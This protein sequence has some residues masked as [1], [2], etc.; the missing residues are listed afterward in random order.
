[1]AGRGAPSG[2][3]VFSI[4]RARPDLEA[5]LDAELGHHFE[6][7]IEGLCDAGWSEAEARLEAER[8]FG[9]RRQYR[10]DLER[11]GRSRLRRRKW[12]ACFDAFRQSVRLAVRGLRRSPGLSLAVVLLLGLGIGANATMFGVIDRV[13]LRPPPHLES[14]DRLR[15]V[16]LHRAGSPERYR[17]SLTY[18]DSQVLPGAR[19]HAARVDSSNP[20]D[21][22][23]RASAAYTVPRQRTMGSGAEAVKVR[24]QLA[25]AELFPTL[26][27][28]PVAG[29][30]FDHRDDTPGAPLTAVISERFW[31]R[32]FGHDP[33][34]LG[35]TV[36]IRQGRYQIVGV[37]PRGFS[38]AELQT[39]DFWL[40]LRASTAVERSERDLETRTMW[41]V[42][43]VIRLAPGADPAQADALLTTSHITSHEAYRANEA[44]TAAGG[45]GDRDYLAANYLETR[46][47][48][49]STTSV[50]AGRGANGTTSTSVAW[51]L[52]G[53]SAV[54]LLIACAN[55]ANLLLVRGMQKQRDVAVRLALGV[56]RRRLIGQALLEAL[57]LAGCGAVGAFFVARWTGT[58][59]H[60]LLIPQ[61]DYDAAATTPRLLVFI[62]LATCFTALLAGLL[63]A[64]QAF[65]AKA[66]ALGLRARGAVA[67]RSQMRG[68][69]IVVQTALSV[70]LLVAAGLFVRSLWKAAGTD[71]GFEPEQALLVTIEARSGLQHERLMG[72]YRQALE[73]VERQPGIAHA[74]LVSGTTPLHGWSATDVSVSRAAGPPTAFDD[75]IYHYA[76]TSDFFRALG[77]R[78]TLGRAYDADAYRVH[79]PPVAMVSESF[80]RSA[81]PDQS[82]LGQCAIVDS[83]R[84][85]G[86][87]S[88]CR[89]VVGVFEDLAVASLTDRHL[90]AV[91]TPTPPDST[92]LQGMVVRTLGDPAQRMAEIRERIR[93]LSPE[94]RFVN[95]VPM[96]QR[97]ERLTTPWRLGG[98]L[99]SAFGLLA[100]VVAGAGLGSFLAFDVAQRQTELGIRAALG[101]SPRALLGFV[102]RRTVLFVAT[103]LMLGTV[104]A[105]G[106]G[107]FVRDLLFDVT[108]ADPLVF[109]VVFVILGAVGALAGLVPARRATGTDPARTM[110]ET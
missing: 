2:R 99:F 13:L 43:A 1:M 34:V 49:L 21:S 32:H 61:V 66:T 25:T 19:S 22:A 93:G 73:Q 5:E 80:A 39:V 38:G 57:L 60:A 95:T 26:G 10:R 36:S 89:E 90:R 92:Q 23:I 29:R 53:V 88:P 78:I 54:V 28:A 102:V 97:V 59:V 46:R 6:K 105:L 91:A 106:A 101:A 100:L 74:A 30:F 64:L 7:T 62:A 17:R 44:R 33:A 109:L 76:G 65:S 67:L 108:P 41:W 58:L 4:F 42:R 14:P 110:R 47:P 96:V 50:V 69:L 24:V 37:A 48:V 87:Q 9:D 12:R 8:R 3:R 82:P 75:E 84:E 18:P 27:V 20:G 85:D 45:A 35:R 52:T 103:G 72:L 94:V 16:S 77:I 71:L 55:V 79:A 70:L 11:I 56:S 40:P 86:E 98:A 107:P 83:D 81:W 63:P 31:G 104:L 68:A 15:L 51:W